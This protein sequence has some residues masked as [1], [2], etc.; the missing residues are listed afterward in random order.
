MKNLI[1]EGEK[2]YPIYKF[3]A[4]FAQNTERTDY[5]EHS[6]WTNG[7]SKKRVW[8]STCFSR[9]YK[10]EKTQG[11]LD[12]SVME[13]WDKFCANEKNAALNLKLLS[14][15]VEFFEFE[16]WNLTW[17]QHETFDVGQTDEEALKSFAKFVSRKKSLNEKQQEIDGKDVYC[18]MGAEDRWRWHGA[19][20][21]KRSSDYSKAPCR[22]KLCKKQGL[23]RIDH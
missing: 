14:L 13:W 18:L 9:M 22:C 6:I 17:F 23:I 16:T 3:C 19:M 12:N 2:A 20:L 10:E 7:L 1:I 15:K 8:N 5:N 21:N 11:W 4:R